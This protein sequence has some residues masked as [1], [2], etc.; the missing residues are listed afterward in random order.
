MRY[1]V[2]AALVAAMTLS[3]C[4]GEGLQSPVFGAVFGLSGAAV[5][6][7]TIGKIPEPEAHPGDRLI[8]RA[9]NNP[10]L[11][12]FENAAGRRFR[13]DCP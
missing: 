5:T 4:A 7:H 10:G 1:D 3:G 2:A 12:I 13:A 9:A 8:G 6:P 11:C